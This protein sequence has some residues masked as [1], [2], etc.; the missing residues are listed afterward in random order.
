MMYGIELPVGTRF[1]MSNRDG[2][3]Q[4]EIEV[5]E[6]SGSCSRQRCAMWHRV[7]VYMNADVVNRTDA[8]WLK[9][10]SCTRR[11]KKDVF[12]EEVSK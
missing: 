10:V 6:D 12:F 5:K 8:Y 1:W 7:C 11:D 9:C 4:V 2:S 3:G